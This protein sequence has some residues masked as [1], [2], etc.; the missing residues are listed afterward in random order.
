M[1]QFP[2][3]DILLGAGVGKWPTYYNCERPNST[4]G[5]LTPDEAYVSKIEPM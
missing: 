1:E 4:H 5:I 2:D 3:A